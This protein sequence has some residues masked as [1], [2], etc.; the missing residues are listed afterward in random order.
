MSF[1]ITVNVR[2]LHDKYQLVGSIVRGSL[3]CSSL[4]QGRGTL[5][6]KTTSYQS[7][8]VLNATA[9]FSIAHRATQQVSDLLKA[10]Y[11]SYP[12]LPMYT[13]SMHGQMCNYYKI[14]LNTIVYSTKYNILLI[15]VCFTSIVIDGNTSIQ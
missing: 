5:H 13:S 14:H 15:R 3:P 7:I 11:I 4:Y 10:E 9:G 12:E 8:P 6:R 1:L 2:S